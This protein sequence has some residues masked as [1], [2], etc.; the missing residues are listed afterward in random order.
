MSQ[1]YF[2][3]RTQSAKSVLE[4]ASDLCSDKVIQ[5]KSWCFF[6]NDF[7]QE[8]DDDDDSNNGYIEDDD[9]IDR[10]ISSGNLQQNKSISPHDPRP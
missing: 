3:E 4:K 8:N 10:Q 5:S 2:L 6:L 7:F 9:P 1:G